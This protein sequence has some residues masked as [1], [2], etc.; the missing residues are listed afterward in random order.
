MCTSTTA[1]REPGLRTA[2]AA[3]RAGDTLVVTKLDRLARSLRD[4]T[5]IADELTKKDVAL[6]LWGAVYDLTDPMGRLLFDRLC[7]VAEFEAD[8]IRAHTREGMAIAEAASKLRGGKPKLNKAQ[9]KHLVDLHR[10]GTHTNSDLAELFDVGRATVD[11]LSSAP[12]RSREHAQPPS[13]RDTP[14][15]ATLGGPA[16]RAVEASNDF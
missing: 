6:N 3:V 14:Q 1:C 8:L 11:G 15:R 2:L 13:Q 7:M 10:A 4:A 5:D 16:P 12:I 9:E